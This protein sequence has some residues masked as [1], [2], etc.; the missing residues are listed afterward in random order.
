VNRFFLLLALCMA[1]CYLVFSRSFAYIPIGIV[2][3][4][5]FFLVVFILI[6]P[7]QIISCVFGYLKNNQITTLLALVFILWGLFESLRGIIFGS[8]IT[9]SLRGFASH[10]Y[11]LFL[12]IGIFLG[13][14]IGSRQ[15]SIF[16]YWTSIFISAWGIFSNLVLEPMK[17]MAPW[18]TEL[19]LGSGHVMYPFAAV[20]IL[21]FTSSYGLR[22]FLP[23]F[24]CL[25][26]VILHAKRIFWLSILIGSSACLLIQRRFLVMKRLAVACVLLVL[27]SSIFSNSLHEFTALR[28]TFTLPWLF[29]RLIEPFSPEMA[30]WVLSESGY[31]DAENVIL[32]R[33]GTIHWRFE[34][35]SA[36]LSSLNTPVLF[37][38]G[39]GYGMALGELYPIA[40][41]DN[42]TPHN[43]LLYFVGYTG[44]IG[45]LIYISLMA[46]LLGDIFKLPNTSVRTFLISQYFVFMT[47]ALTGNVLETPQFAVPF[48]LITGIG[49]GCA[50]QE[51]ARRL[52]EQ[53]L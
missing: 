18:N 40:G 35:W 38:F 6:R 48:Y 36:I 39:H 31:G 17:I 25:F 2:Y 26:G 22:P 32:S 45:L 12:F 13:H 53:I 30:I 10:Y 14:F 50:L 4:A 5:E 7:A 27:L 9:Y 24:L 41:I 44:A 29:A 1:F 16:L 3:P 49:Y 19:L 34:F 20:S 51:R 47:F 46:S 15:F 37:L 43:F 33:H 42:R 28:E 21:A 8:D 52:S 23:L 11:I